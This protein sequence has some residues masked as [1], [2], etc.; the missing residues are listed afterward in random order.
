MTAT[1]EHSATSVYLLRHG[2]C[3]GGQI[4]RGHTD[5]APTE[6]G[7]HLMTRRLNSLA[8]QS[9]TAVVSSPAQR[10]Q[11]AA[12]AFASDQSL[13]FIGEQGFLE[14]DFGEWEGQLVS[15]VA[16]RMPRE[17]EQFWRDPVSYTPPMGET[18]L[19][20]QAR[21]TAAWQKLLAQ[22][23]GQRLVLVTHGGVIRMILANVLAMPLRPLSHLAVPHGCLSCVQ[24]HHAEGKPDWPQLLFH[25]GRVGD[26]N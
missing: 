8:G 3:E 1:L 26:D 10:C 9:L 13:A 16:D 25:N 7:R 21:V 23:R 24:Y 15:A 20:F 18:L 6:V 14:I 12:E 5:S 22:Y 11:L 4:F 2:Q 17:L 19:A